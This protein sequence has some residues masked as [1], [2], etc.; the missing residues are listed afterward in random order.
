[1]GKFQIVTIKELR[2]RR[3]MSQE[4]ISLFDDFKAHITKLDG[5]NAGIYEFSNG[6]DHK[7]T[8]KI[9]KKAAAALEVPIRV[10]EKDVCLVFY[11]RILRGQKKQKD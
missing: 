5:K 10:K 1:M 2:S 9:L 11:R 6:E 3:K 8:R 4:E 7:K